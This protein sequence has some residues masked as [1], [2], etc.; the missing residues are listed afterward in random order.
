MIHSSNLCTEI[1]LNTSA[2]ETAVCNLGSVNL[3]RAPG[4]RRRLDEERLAQTVQDGDPDAR[5]RHQHQLLPHRRGAQLEPA[6]PPDRPRPDGLPGRAVPA[7]HALRGSATRLSSS[8]TVIHGADLLQR[9]PLLIGLAERGPT[10]PTRAPSGT[11]ASCPSTPSSCWSSERGQADRGLAGSRSSR[12][13]WTAGP[14]ARA[15]A[16]HAQ[17]E[18][19]GHRAHRDDLEHL[20]GCFPCIEPIY[21]NIYVKANIS[22][23]SSRSSTLPGRGPQKLGLWDDEMLD[24]IKYFDGNISLIPSD[25]GRAQGEVQGGVRGRRSVVALS[26]PP[27]AAS[28]STRASRTTSS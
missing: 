23:A 10:L 21:K 5:Q 4:R 7:R 17:L 25:P 16:R 24:K 6:A 19:D 28:G 12:L 26:S 15:P 11:G 18:H 8:A 27:P 22:V 20:A 1:T 9:D 3:A 2:E 14:R 13:D